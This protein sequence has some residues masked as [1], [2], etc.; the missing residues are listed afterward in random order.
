MIGMFLDKEEEKMWNGEYGEAV[1]KAIKVI[2]KVG[3][4]LGADSLVKIAHSHVSGVSY[5]TVGEP[6]LYFI[7]HL[8]MKGAKVSVYATLNPVGADLE[9]WDKIGVPEKFV[10]K[11][12]ELVDILF[13]MGFQESLTCTPYLLRRPNINEHLAWGESSAVG[14]A[15][16]FFGA[17]TNREGGPL[18]LMSAIIGRTYNAGLHVLENRK[19][20]FLVEL[21]SDV[22]FNDPGIAG[23][24]GYIVGEHLGHGIPYI[25]TRVSPTFDSIKA[26]TAAAGASGGIG[27]S[28]IEGI[29]PPGTYILNEKYEDKLTISFSDIK[30]YIVDPKEIEPDLVFIGC[31]HATIEELEN[32][33]HVLAH[34]CERK[35][36]LKIWVS[37]SRYVYEN[38]KIMGLIEKLEKE[39]VLIIK[40]TCPIVSPATAKRFRNIVTISGKSYFY[41]PKMQET[42]TIVLPHEKLRDVVCEK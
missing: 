25:R 35:K 4:S 23:I 42:P 6:G 2:V 8:W 13:K 27:M 21:S 16:T 5:Y 24:I 28:V 17:Y 33:W 11:Q 26:Y 41:L 20:D 38:A 37:T 3:E 9:Q 1:E 14:M 34:N 30:E 39:G 10:E 32:L 36:E 18:S 12:K 19:P 29:T 7:R 31:P 15:N 22:N 40:D